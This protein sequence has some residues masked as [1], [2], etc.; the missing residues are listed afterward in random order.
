MEKNR[1]RFQLLSQKDLPSLQ[2]AFQN[3]FNNYTD[4]FNT[5]LEALKYRMKCIGAEM[6]TTMA[7]L[8]NDEIAAFIINAIGIDNGMKTA[9]NGGTGVIPAYRGHKLSADLYL[10][11]FKYLKEQGIEKCLLEV[12]SDNI[13]A[14][15]IYQQLGFEVSREFNCY[16]GGTIIQEKGNKDIHFVA[17]K[18]RLPDWSLYSTWYDFEPCWQNNQKSVIRNYTNQTIIEAIHRTK[19][20]GIVIFESLNGKVAQLAVDPAYRRLKIGTQLLRVVRNLSKA[21]SI[22]F[23]NIDAASGSINKFLQ[24][25]GFEVAIKQKEMIKRL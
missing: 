4:N 9:Y 14:F 17:V 16:K 1:I 10:E 20:V 23:L 19:T 6:D 18:D 8:K 5:S 11:G 25:N 12:I 3:A 15:K 22:V 21:K 7:A 13:P 24:K 2:L